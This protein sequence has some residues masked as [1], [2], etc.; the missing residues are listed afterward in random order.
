LVAIYSDD[1]FVS[2]LAFLTANLKAIEQSR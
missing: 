1:L 2:E